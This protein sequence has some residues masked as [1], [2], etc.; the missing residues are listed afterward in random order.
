MNPVVSRRGVLL[1][2]SLCTLAICGVAGCE[3]YGPEDEPASSSASSPA[4]TPLTVPT[5]DVPV[6]GGKIFDAQKI[7]VTQPEAGH[8]KAFSAVCTHQ[9]CTVGDVTT[10][11][12]CP[13]HGSRYSIADGS[14]VQGPATTPLPPYPVKVSGAEVTVG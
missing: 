8:F 9:G 4:A 11:I 12:N 6:D 14:V 13:C 7:V 2:G 10:T 1:G 5:A 3:S